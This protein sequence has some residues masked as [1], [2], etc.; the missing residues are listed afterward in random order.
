[1]EKSDMIVRNLR[2][3]SEFS[4]LVVAAFFVRNTSAL[5]GLIVLGIFAL[6]TC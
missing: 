3:V 4:E 1:M 5:F 2:D 6:A